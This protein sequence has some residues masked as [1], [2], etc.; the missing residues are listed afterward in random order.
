MKIVK[1]N[2]DIEVRI[3][4]TKKTISG[5]TY[6]VTE[7]YI[8]KKK[9]GEV[10]AYGPKEFQSFMDNEE[11]GASKSLDLAIESIIRQWNLHE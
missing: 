7:L 2:K 10:L 6:D 5:S 8:G 4:E 9:I 1:K 11:L 3:E